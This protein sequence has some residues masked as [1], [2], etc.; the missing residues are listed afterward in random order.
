M[1]N[2]INK[3]ISAVVVFAFAVFL[4]ARLSLAQEVENKRSMVENYTQKVVINSVLDMMGKTMQRLIKN[5]NI[6]LYPV[7]VTNAIQ[8]ASMQVFEQ[9]STKNIAK[10]AY[11]VTLDKAL[12]QLEQNIPQ[13]AIQQNIRDSV[14]EILRKIPEDPIYKKIV[15]EVLKTAAGQQQKILAMALAQQ[16]AQIAV[17]QQQYQMAQQALMEQYQQQVIMRYS[18]EQAQQAYYQQQAVQSK[19][20]GMMK[21]EYERRVRQEYESR[22]YSQ[23]PWK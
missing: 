14:D 10:E 1:K 8:A 20:N 18:H 23:T 15:E 13:E 3:I 9:E 11:Q 2:K 22:V 4:I 16:Q 5:N 12:K 6:G 19:Y 17:M 21:E 7:I